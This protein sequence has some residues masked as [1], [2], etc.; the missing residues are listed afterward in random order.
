M[1]S[2]SMVD[3]N[4]RCNIVN[5]LQIVIY[6]EN[7]KCNTPICYKPSFFYWE[8]EHNT[9]YIAYS[10]SFFYF[11]SPYNTWKFYF[12]SQMMFFIRMD[13]KKKNFMLSLGEGIWTQ[14]LWKQPQFAKWRTF[15]YLFA[16][17]SYI[18]KHPK[19]RC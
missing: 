5:F 2:L 4:G 16:S 14:R 12:G 13:M 3:E 11:V 7:E 1:P 6:H 15:S 8:N 18:W 9:H 19:H 10:I 17:C